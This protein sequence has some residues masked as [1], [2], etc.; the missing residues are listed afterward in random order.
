MEKSGFF[1]ANL[2]NEEYDRVYL[3]EDFA[4][5]FESFISNGVFAK[6]SNQLQV[7]A[8]SDPAM[9]VQV[10][11]GRGWI[12][13]YFY[14]NT[15]LFHLAVELADG[16]LNRID[17]VVL[18]LDFQNRA[19]NLKIKKG[20]PASSPVAPT[21][22]RNNDYYEL[23]LATIAVNAGAIN[24]TQAQIT[25]TRLNTE[26]CGWVTGTVTQID[27][28]TLF[29]QFNDYFEQFKTSSEDEFNEWEAEQKADFESWFETI[30]DQL[31]GDIAANLQNQVMELDERVTIVETG[32]ENAYTLVK[33]TL[34][35]DSWV[36]TE[37]AN[38]YS[39][40]STYP[41]SKYKL[42]L[43]P[44][45][46]CDE[47]ARDAWDNAWIT[48]SVDSNDVK[49]LNEVPTVDIPCYLKVIA[50][51]NPDSAKAFN[52]YTTDKDTGVYAEVENKDYNLS[53]FVKTEE[54][55]QP[56]LYNLEIDK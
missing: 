32:K 3:A 29:E 7:I 1:N 8:E 31:S 22:T 43:Y 18:Q 5:Y 19:I 39:F 9:S 49:A 28:T 33:I 42:E 54:E 41:V 15:D 36:T 50:L 23:Q 55:L 46:T 34:D 27:T 14:E 21:L 37:G 4:S 48:G 56:G 53:G 6:Y 44:G 16:V 45:N 24:V 17:S 35:K 51:D 38:T 30:K 40:E 10:S 52:L 25:D 12:N 47:D 11:T 26:V 13:G 20:T 2:V